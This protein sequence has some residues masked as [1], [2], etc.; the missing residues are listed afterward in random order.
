MS[1]NGNDNGHG[2]SRLLFE[3]EED[4]VFDMMADVPFTDIEAMPTAMAADNWDLD[5]RDSAT[6]H[7][8]AVFGEPR[9]AGDKTI[10]PVAGVRR[11]YGLRGGWSSAWPVA[12][13]EIDSQGVRVKPVINEAIIPL[14]GML[15]GAWNVYWLLRAIREWRAHR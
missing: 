5:A 3:E 11:A 7:V 15:L 9:T 10:I 6:A 13:I 14:A 4:A 2:P 12:V 1:R 8:S